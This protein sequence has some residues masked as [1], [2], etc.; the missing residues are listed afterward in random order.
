MHVS[1]DVS[2][3]HVHVGIYLE[4]S[5]LLYIKFTFADW[6][7]MCINVIHSIQFLYFC[8]HEIYFFKHQAHRHKFKTFHTI[9][10]FMSTLNVLLQTPGASAQVKTLPHNSCH[11]VYINFTLQTP[12]TWPLVQNLPFNF[13]PCVYINFTFADTR[14][15][16]TLA[17]VQNL[18]YNSCSCVYR[19]F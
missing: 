11:C 17:Q 2:N 18:P 9:P 7:R 19:N 5:P 16:G 10:V 4:Y 1:I 15:I 3:Y 6:M 12:G 14:H 8:E 13:C